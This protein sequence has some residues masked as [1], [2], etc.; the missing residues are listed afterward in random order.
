MYWLLLVKVFNVFKLQECNLEEVLDEEDPTRSLKDPKKPN[1]PD[2][3][4]PGLIFKITHKV[5]YK[6]VLKGTFKSVLIYTRLFH[7]FVF[8][9]SLITVAAHK[10]IILKAESMAEKTEW[11][12]KIRSIVDQKGAS[13]TSGLPMR[14]SHSDGSLMST[15][16]KDGSL[17]SQ[18]PSFILQKVHREKILKIIF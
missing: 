14:Q 6:N 8:T 5:A 17:V 7:F 9:C 1:V 2:I 16:K 4:T 10:A 12:T 3:G 11:V 15:S 13:A 18:N